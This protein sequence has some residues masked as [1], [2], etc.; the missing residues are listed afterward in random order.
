[1]T[2]HAQRWIAA[3]RAS[4]RNANNSFCCLGVAC[5]LLK[6]DGLGK[7]NRSSEIEGFIEHPES[8][9]MDPNL[10]VDPNLI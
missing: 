9:C 2:P 4:L 7:W 8:F 6:K 10:S 1:M 3:L 5:D